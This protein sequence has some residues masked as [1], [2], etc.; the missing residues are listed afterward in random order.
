MKIGFDLPALD[1]LPK[2]TIK[3][4]IKTEIKIIDVNNPEF[5]FKWIKK[6][7]HFPVSGYIKVLELNNWLAS[8]FDGKL[9]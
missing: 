6:K 7:L 8:V 1:P 3:T 5:D 4:E 2:R 9:A